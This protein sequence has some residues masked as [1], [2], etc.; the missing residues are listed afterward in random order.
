MRDGASRINQSVLTKKGRAVEIA[1]NRDRREL[2]I[3]MKHD[4]EPNECFAWNKENTSSRTATPEHTLT[5]RRFHS[6][7]QIKSCVH[8]SSLRR[9]TDLRLVHPRGGRQGI[10]TYNWR[11]RNCR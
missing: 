1:A 5:G 7:A 6:D 3:A 10:L 9:N 11:T 4:S 8:P 2:D